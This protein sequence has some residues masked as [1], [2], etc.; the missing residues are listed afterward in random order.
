MLVDKDQRFQYVNLV[1]SAILAIVLIVLTCISTHLSTDDDFHKSV[2]TTQMS[3]D[4]VKPVF[5]WHYNNTWKSIGNA[6]FKHKIYSAYFD[7]RIDII[8]NLFKHK[9]RKAIGSVRVFTILSLGFRDYVTCIFRQRDFSTVKIRAV[10]VKPLPE[11]KDIKYAVFTIVCPLGKADNGNKIMHLPQEVAISYPSNTLANFHPTFVPISY[12]RNMDQLFAKS[13]PILSVCVAPLQK[14]YRNVLRIAEFVEMYRLLGAKHFYFYEDNHSRDVKRLLKHY[15]KEGIADVL[16]WNLETYQDDSY[17]NG[18]IAQINDCSYRA[19]IVD[20]YRYA[21][22][23]DLD[24]ILM[25][26]NFNSLMG[27]LRKCDKGQTSAFVFC[28][29]FFY[30]K[31]GNDTYSTPIYARNRFLYT[32][33]KVRRADQIKPVYAQ[34]KCIINTHSVLEMGK[35]RMWK[36]VSGYSELILQPNVGILHHY[37]DKCYN[38]KKTLVIDYTARRFGSLIWDR[39]DEICLQA[40][41]KDNGICPTS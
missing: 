2:H 39:V 23:V 9:Y 29:A 22:I 14:H 3:L 37:R 16:P 27:Y 5:P 20:N 41:F 35:N 18:I 32:Q 26:V 33:T 12:P 28:N 4:L 21:A 17:F 8:E 13:Q 19:M 1:L 24:E 11:R 25:P 15:R 6:S 40:F 30:M 31:D 38:C 36:S 10:Q 7:R 34:S